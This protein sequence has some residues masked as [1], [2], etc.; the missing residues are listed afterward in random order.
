MPRIPTY[1]NL[2]TT[3]TAPGVTPMQGSVGPNAGQIQAQQGQELATGLQRAGDVGTRL[4]VDHQEHLNILS[5]RAQDIDATVKLNALQ[6]DP[7]AGFMSKSGLNAVTSLPEF[8]R[9]AKEIRDNALLNAPNEPVR[10]MLDN[11]VSE[12]VASATASASNHAAGELRKAHIQTSDDRAKVSINAAAN[13]FRNEAAFVGNLGT[14]LQEARAQG[15]MQGWDGSTTQLQAQRYQDDA[16]KQRYE[17]WRDADPVGALT[18][19]QKNAGAISPLVRVQLYHQLFEAAA[20]S[21]AAQLNASGGPGVVPAVVNAAGV[22]G[23]EPRGVRNNNPGNIIRTNAQWQGE[24]QSNDPKYSAFSSP[25]AGIRAMGKTL[26]TYQDVHGL[27]TVNAV[28]S[29]WAPA[30]EAGNDPASYAKHVAAIMG[31]KPDQPLNLHDPATLA[32]ITKGI[33][34]HENGKQPY[35][36]QQITLGLASTGSA[37]PPPA[38]DGVPVPPPATPGAADAWRNPAVPTG[39]PVIDALPSDFKLHVLQVARTQ[40]HQDMAGA[41]DLLRSKVQDAS[42]A[43]LVNGTAPNPPALAEFI[44][45]YGQ[46]E[47]PAQY[48]SFQNVAKLGQQLQQVK[49]LP[50]AALSELARQAKPVAGP[51]F[52][53]AQR[54]YEILTTAI[55]RTNQARQSDPVAYAQASGAYGYGTKA[56]TDFDF[57]NVDQLTKVMAR[58]AGVA[59]S[60]SADYGTAPAL[61]SKAEAQAFS[62]ALRAAPVDTQK[63]YLAAV[64]GGVGDVN[65]MKATMQ[66][67]APDQPVLAMAGVYQARGFKTM[68]GRDVAGLM[69]RGQAILTPNKKADGTGHDGGASL[70]KMPEEKLL[71]MTFNDETG[72]AFTGKEQARDLF[73]QSAR[74]IYAAKSAEAGDYS[75]ILDTT[76]MKTAINLATG[77]I[78]EH[79]GARIVMPYGRSYDDFVNGLKARVTAVAPQVLAAQPAE[80][81]R[82][83][84]ENVGDGR[85]M[86]KRGAGYLV[87]KSGRPVVV[88]MTAR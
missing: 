84:L 45:A 34:Q 63:K 9:S 82:L 26:L 20:P 48:A 23:P 55:D 62:A 56:L 17:A 81:M 12:R 57:G 15:E 60:M 61:F 35:T 5:A 52:A 27:N 71:A 30:G 14:A 73:M 28:V 33:I 36:D 79:N 42:A 58:R 11:I 29:R 65:L 77:G 69:L 31:V 51:G 24:V 19:F 40:A 78:Q 4:A 44:Q 43:Y 66:A 47:G 76:R 18:H 16:Y 80:M 67:I 25:E 70:L 75:G 6:F 41:R 83:P 46:A 64:A 49:T 21:L 2:Q 53:D 13:D 7:E 39:N 54:N 3:P 1:D 74:A 59:G 86:F 85:Y 87:D 88:D 10:Q 50:A 8:K 38:A 68:S 22:Q 72:D 37:P 32:S